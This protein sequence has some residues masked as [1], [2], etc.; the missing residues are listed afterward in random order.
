MYIYKKIGEEIDNYDF[1]QAIESS[2]TL[3]NQAKKSNDLDYISKAYRGLGYIYLSRKDSARARKNFTFGLEYA[4]KAKNDTLILNSYNNLG[5][6]Y[7][8][9]P[10]TRNKGIDYYN[11]VIELASKMND[12]IDL[13]MPKSNIGWTYLDIEKYEK[14]YPYIKEAKE[15]MDALGSPENE[16]D[17]KT[18]DYFN[19]QIYMLHGRYYSHKK[20]FDTSRYFFNKSIELALKDSLVLGAVEVYESYSKMLA[21]KGDYEAAL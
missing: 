16:E 9:I 4:Q 2:Y 7:S 15:I 10:E 6:I 14:A 1:I 13:V 3:L 11:K 17:Q 21:R 12:S 19:S 20:E 8:E 5:N 18:Y